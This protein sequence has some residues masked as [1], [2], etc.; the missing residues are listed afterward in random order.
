MNKSMK[1]PPER[2]KE[3]YKESENGIDYLLRL[4]KEVIPEWDKTKS[5]DGYPEISRN[6]AEFIINCVTNESMAFCMLWLN[7]GFSC[8]NPDIEDWFV[9]TSDVKLIF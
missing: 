6:T 8:N 2:I 4:Y 7:K 9:D 3:L 1:L 5:I